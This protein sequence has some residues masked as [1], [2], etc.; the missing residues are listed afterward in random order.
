MIKGRVHSI[1]SMGLMDGPGVRSV[2]FFQGCK[3]RCAYCHNPDTWDIE[4]GFE[5][6]ADELFSKLLR[7]KPYLKKNGGIT[8]SGGEPLLQPEFLLELLKL[9]RQE[10]INTALDTSGVGLGRMYD[11]ILDLTDLVILDI[12]HIDPTDYFDLTGH[13]IDNFY[14]FQ[15]ILN[16]KQKKI[17]IRHVVVPGITDDTSHIKA[18]KNRLEIFSNIE[19]IELLP[20]HTMGLQKYKKMGIKNRLEGIPSCSNKSIVNLKK[21]INC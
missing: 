8:F 14:E 4:G 3:L 2:V 12:K 7:F 6:S 18:L 17:W 16:K 9:C 5:F 20:Y 19:K 11:E 13:S 10:G 1:E 15:E 21:I